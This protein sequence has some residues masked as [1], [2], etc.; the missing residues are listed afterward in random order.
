MSEGRAKKSSEPNSRIRGV[1]TKTECGKFSGGI[2]GIERNF[3]WLDSFKKRGGQPGREKAPTSSKKLDGG[4]NC[5]VGA[6]QKKSR[7]F[8]EAVAKN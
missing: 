6:T 5:E 8:N 3:Q 7:T 1:K 2:R 4:M